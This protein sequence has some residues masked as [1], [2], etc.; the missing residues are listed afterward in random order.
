MKNIFHLEKRGGENF[1]WSEFQSKGEEDE[2]T[3]ISREQIKLKLNN[4]KG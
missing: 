1:K 4:T 2:D 3:L